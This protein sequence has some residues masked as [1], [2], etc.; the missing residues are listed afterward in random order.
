MT[1]PA[2]KSIDLVYFNAGGGHRAAASALDTVIKESGRP[3]DVRRTNLMKVLDPKEI[4]LK[5]T[6][7]NWEDLYNT[8]LA[9]GWSVGLA[10]ELKLLQA[11]VR[12]THRSMALRLKRHWRKTRPDMVVSLIPNFNRPMYEGSTLANPTAP[13]VTI[14]T[15]FAD[16]PP[17]FW[18]EPHQ[19]QHFICGTRR[20]VEQAHALGYDDAHVHATSGMIIRPDFY[21]ESH[22]D[23]RVELTKLG[24]DPD[25]PTGI[26]MFGGHGSRVMLKLAKRLDD[27]QLI[28]ICG[29]NEA[30][31]NRLRELPAS[32]PRVVLG[33]TSEI[34]HFMQLCDY[35]IGKPGPGSISEAVQQGLPVIVVH[36]TWT[37]PQERYNSEWIRENQ[38]GIVLESYKFIRQGVDEVIARLPEFRAATG[39]IRNRAVFEIPDILEHILANDT[40]AVRTLGPAFEDGEEETEEELES[41]SALKI[42]ARKAFSDKPK[43]LN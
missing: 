28:M 40:R 1:T 14:L 22:V 5:T 33:F 36:N 21:R 35:F 39:R 16:Y 20:A 42:A 24:L 31:A 27:L 2:R 29:H 7:M 12:L 30:L 15:D 3:W 9:R 8:R 26:V 34:R 19:T 32:A 38:T 17:H 13:Y 43:R 25:R 4:F 10:Q 6:G 23:R 11:L 37:M 18:I 41:V